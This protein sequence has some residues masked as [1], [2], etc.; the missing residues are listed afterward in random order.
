MLLFIHRFQKC[1]Y[2]TL[3]FCSCF[4]CSQ[5][6][7]NTDTSLSEQSAEIFRTLQYLSSVMDSMK[8]P[9]GTRENPARFCRDL[10]DCQ[11]KMSDGEIHS[12][13]NQ[14][15]PLWLQAVLSEGHSDTSILLFIL[16]VFILILLH[17]WVNMLFLSFLLAF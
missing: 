7:Q 13:L 16:F 17:N 15:R 1:F 6:Y 10:L 9:L 8:T 12:S 2:F 14:P 3:D 4:L 5:S 11:H